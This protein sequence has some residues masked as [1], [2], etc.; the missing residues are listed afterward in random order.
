[1][2]VWTGVLLAAVLLAPSV[3]A[4]QA[5]DYEVWVVD[6]ANAAEG[7]ARLHVF[8][9]SAISPSGYAGQPQVVDLD[10]AAQGVGAGP[11]V[12]PHLLLFNRDHTH[13]VLAYVASGHVQVI[14]AADRAVVASI[15]VGEQAHGALPSP[16]DSFI[17][18]ANQ[19]GKKLAKI[20]ADYQQEQFSHNPAEDFDLKALEDEQHPDNAPICP[21]M[22]AG[23]SKKAYVTLR[24]GGLFVV[25]TSTTPMQV[26]KSYGKDQVAPAGCGGVVVG[27]KMYVNSGLATSGAIYIFDLETDELIKTIDTTA[28]GTDA[29]GMVVVGGN[30]Y[31]WMA[32]RGDGD[33][34]VVLDTASGELVGAFDGLGA[35]PDLMDLAPSGDLVFV[36]LRGQNALTGGPS[37]RGETPGMA[38]VSVQDEGRRGARAFFVPIGEPTSSSDPHALAVRRIAAAA[39]AAP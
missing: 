20:A 28:Q 36:S 24:G 37:A 3:G 21:V 32:N 31:L 7:G 34:I 14:R 27:N 11:G 30:R 23:Q 35:A 29:H 22:F 13:G 12:R 38:V 4:A 26:V 18:V 33:N 10:A 1:M 19:N 39:T 6:Q 17:L 25:D 8:S 5:A 9:G 16:D 15:D 2:K